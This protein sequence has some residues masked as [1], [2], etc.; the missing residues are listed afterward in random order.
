MRLSHLLLLVCIGL[1]S[2]CSKA[3]QWQLAQGDT[4]SLDTLRGQW[5]LMNYWAEW[6]KPCIT[7]IPEL[8]QLDV[9]DDI[10]V[11]GYNFDRLQGDTLSAQA[12]KLGITFDL[13]LQEPATLFGE[14]APKGLPATLVISPQGKVH[15]WLMGPQTTESVRAALASEGG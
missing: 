13:M 3:P 6:C 5:V 12:D 7:E 11:L 2:G 10:T 8:N 15:T 9:A 4:Q 14:S 1:T